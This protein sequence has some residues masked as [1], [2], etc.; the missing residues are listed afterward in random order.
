MRRSRGASSIL[1]G[2]LALAVITG[3]AGCTL[4][5]QRTIDCAFD[6]AGGA[7]SDGYARDVV[8]VIAP[9]DSFVNFSAALDTAAPTIQEALG[10]EGARVSVV[11][12]DGTPSLVRTLR[13]ETGDTADD[14]AIINRHLID[15][16]RE[17]GYCVTNDAE[18]PTTDSLAVDPE[19][20]LLGAL[21]VAAGAFDA[22][23]QATVSRR[24]VVVGNG[25]QTGG[26]LH[27]DKTGVPAESEVNTVVGGLAQQHALPDLGGTS[28]SFVGLGVVNSERPQLNQQ[29]SYAL[30][31]FW[32]GIVLASGGRIGAIIHA[33][34]DGKPAAGAIAVADVA[35]LKDACVNESVAEADGIGFRPGTSDFL[36]P[37]AA[38]AT[39]DQIATK[40]AA[41][42]CTGDITVTGYIASA[43]PRAEFVFGNPDDQALS[44]ARAEAFKGL[45][46]AAGVTV[47]II[48]VGG[49]KGPIDDWDTAGNFVEAAG[50]QNRKVVVTQ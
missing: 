46:V 42:S 25:L 33:V 41:S 27:F 14:T 2:V 30:D 12:A 44:L 40:I 23:G 11:V 37:G 45:L 16:I 39:A 35:G 21:S 28:V 1:A 29:T 3:L 48:A 18:H 24:I 34:I 36:D 43:V 32:T 17:V 31:A 38:R 6:A 8:V 50:A 10:L 47:P 22:T 19:S 7:Q 4:P 15:R 20:D 13:P 26:Q 5:S 9:T 49:G